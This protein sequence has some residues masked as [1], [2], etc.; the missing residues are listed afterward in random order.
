[1]N[2]I[3]TKLA[4]TAKTAHGERDAIAA[5][6]KAGRLANILNVN[7]FTE[8]FNAKGIDAIVLLRPTLSKGLYAQMVGRGLRLQPG[9]TDCLILTK[10]PRRID[11]GADSNQS[12]SL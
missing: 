11:D 4:R 9:K 2:R 1:M 12:A 8:G 3:E 10:P 6:F 5:D 7:V